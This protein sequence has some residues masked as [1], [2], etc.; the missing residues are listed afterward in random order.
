MVRMNPVFNSRCRHHNMNNKDIIENFNLLATTWD[1]HINKSKETINAIFSYAN[2]EKGKDILDVGCGT[3]VLIEDYLEAKVN[4]ITAIDISD[5]MIEIARNKYPN[6]NFKCID[7]TKFN[8]NKLYDAII[9]YNCFPHFVD[10]KET[11]KH[12][13]SLLKENGKL[14]IAHSNNI[15]KLMENNNPKISELIKADEIKKILSTYLKDIKQIDNDH[16][17]LCVGSLIK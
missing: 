17:Y 14:V 16:M 10:K 7:A 11:I 12:L 9:L 3:G 13:S 1:L 8:D 4:S 6:V 2:I 5:K 15:N